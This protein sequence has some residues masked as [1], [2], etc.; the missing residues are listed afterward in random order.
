MAATWHADRCEQIAVPFDIMRI[1]EALFA[2]QLPDLNDPLRVCA[3]FKALDTPS[4]RLS[5]LG[6]LQRGLNLARRAV[7]VQLSGHTV[8]ALGSWDVFFAGHLKVR[9]AS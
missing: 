4:N 5:A 7:D 6:K 9:G 1:L 8:R 3:P 2:G